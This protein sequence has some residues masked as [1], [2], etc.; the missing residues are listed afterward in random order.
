M[1]VRDTELLLELRAEPE[2]LAVADALSD[3]L[4]AGGLERRRR[5]KTW[6]AAGAAAAVTAAAVVTGALLLAANGVQPS[7]VDRALAAVGDAP[8]LHAVIRQQGPSDTTLVELSTGRRIVEQRV[9]QTEIWFDKER[10]LEHTI[11]HTTHLPTQDFLSTPAGVFSESG[12][13]WTCARIAAHPVEATRERVS[14]NFN[15]DN[16]TKPR[17]VPEPPPTLDPA[18]AG[19]VD[20]YREALATGAAR[21]IGEGTIEERQVYWLEFRLPEPSADP[22][23]PAEP[24]VDLREQVAVDSGTYT[25]IVVRPITN[26]VAGLDYRVLEIGTVG[27]DEADFSKPRLLP[28]GERPTSTSVVRT[29]ELEL[30]EASRVLGADALWAGPE[31]AG[32]KLAAVQRQEVT[33]GYGRSSGVPPRVTPVVSLIYGDVRRGHPTSGSLEITESTAPLSVWAYALAPAPAG[34]VSLNVFGWGQLRVG[35]VYVQITGGFPRAAS[36]ELT[37]AAARQLVPVPPPG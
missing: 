8:V 27:R 12:P 22:S 19:F 3:A 32:L 29:G 4:E 28:P 33:S 24:P 30:G 34:F 20:G 6:L 35:D 7:L 9:T 18:L 17:H 11:T 25:P 36:E 5:G 10:S 23:A 1:T 37:V 26:G 13:V 2:L 16:G 21:R 14:C 31:V 15:G